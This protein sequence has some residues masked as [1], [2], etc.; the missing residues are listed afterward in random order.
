MEGG[1]RNGELRFVVNGR[2]V[3]VENPNPRH[4]LGDFLREEMGLKGLQQPCRQGG[5]GACTV[6]L[7]DNTQEGRPV[8]ACLRPICAMDGMAVT[9]IEGVSTLK[10]GLA[11]LQQ[12]IVAHNGSQCGY[13]TPGMVSSITIQR[14]LSF[15][16][17]MVSRHWPIPFFQRGLEAVEL[18][19]P[20]QNA[21]PI[22]AASFLNMTNGYER[23]VTCKFEMQRA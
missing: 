21:V 8:N 11:P 19:N 15:I 2:E 13:C 14:H 23:T 18:H 6:V 9:T 3:K 4:T 1:R 22:G 12:A 17:H 7:S 20:I 10:T 5:C 16:L